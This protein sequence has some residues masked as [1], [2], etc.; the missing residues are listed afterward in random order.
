MLLQIEQTIL[1]LL[2]NLAGSFLVGRA[3][4]ASTTFYPCWLVGQSTQCFVRLLAIWEALL[5]SGPI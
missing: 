2:G 1:W 5:V 4:I 3:F